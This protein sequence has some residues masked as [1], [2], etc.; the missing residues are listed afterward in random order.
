MEYEYN[1]PSQSTYS[2]P[3]LVK[4]GRYW[5]IRVNVD[6]GYYETEYGVIDTAKPTRKRRQIKLNESGR[7]MAAQCWLE[8]KQEHKKKRQ[9]DYSLAVESTEPVVSV[10][11]E[12]S[13]VRADAYD[14]LA[15]EIAASSISPAVDTAPLIYNDSK[16]LLPM[17]A[18]PLEKREKVKNGVK[19]P[20]ALQPKAN[21]VRG[22]FV[23]TSSGVLIYT[24]TLHGY[25]FMNSLRLAVAEVLKHAPNLVLDGEIY[26]HGVAGQNITSIATQKTKPHP[27]E[28]LACLHVFDCYDSL[29]ASLPYSE[30]RKIL[31]GLIPTRGGRV[32]LMPET[33]VHNREEM[34]AAHEKYR[35]MW[36]GSML[37]VLTAPYAH[38][39]SNDLIKWKFDK[40]M[41]TVIT[42]IQRTPGDDAILHLRME[43]GKT[44]THRPEGSTEDKEDWLNDSSLV[45]GRIY[46]FSYTH[47]TEDGIPLAIHGG[48]IRFDLPK[49]DTSDE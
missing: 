46:S 18:Q 5:T 45:I 9:N 22:L 16:V 30:R 31:E 17:L 11:S 23:Y 3:L 13:T 12:P 24:R 8:A 6:E 14:D 33:I 28:D 35:G 49:C 29:D 47:L 43:N 1:R 32:V 48:M 20:L 34:A 15:D 42:D 10:A 27:D 4:N 44:F 38:R 40:E 37:R 2:L 19:F 7:D 36:E 39:R 26:A 25:L 21:G 41:D